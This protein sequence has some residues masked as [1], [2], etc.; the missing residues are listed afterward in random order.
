MRSIAAKLTALQLVCAVLVVA[1]LFT[2]INRQLSWRMTENFMVHGE[3]V[4]AAL[5]KSVSR[6]W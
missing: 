6:R 4:A 5:A 1:V 3:V 2:L